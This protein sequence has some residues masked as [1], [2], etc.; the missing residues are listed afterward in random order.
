MD[1]TIGMLNLDMV[2]RANGGVDI[3]GLDLSPSM[4]ADLRAAEKASGDQLKIRREGPGAGR[5]D[6]SSFIDKRVP[7][8]NF[9][10]GFH[11]DYHRPGDDWEKIDARGVSQV[12]GL[13]LEMAARLAGRTDRPEFVAPKGN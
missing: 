9:F 7:A 5:S 4:E 2:G 6:D 13:A 12:A 1:N 8:I 10:T 11:A 3:S